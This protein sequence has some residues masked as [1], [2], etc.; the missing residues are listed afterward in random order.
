M[1][2][3]LV[4]LLNLHFFRGQ[5][6]SSSI[7]SVFNNISRAISN[8][9]SHRGE[10]TICHV[11]RIYCQTYTIIGLLSDQEMQDTMHALH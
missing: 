11:N 9:E 5:G 6:V 7:A 8:C 1:T 10:V 2:W 3:F 4:P